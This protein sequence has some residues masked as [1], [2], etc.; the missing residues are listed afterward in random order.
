MQE[1]DEGARMV[2]MATKVENGLWFDTFSVRPECRAQR[3][4]SKTCVDTTKLFE[5]ELPF[6]VFGINRRAGS[7]LQR[8]CRKHASR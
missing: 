5:P 2:Y 7:C 4:V 1:V 8:R 3:G 6:R